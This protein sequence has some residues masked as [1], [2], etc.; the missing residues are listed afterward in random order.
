VEFRSNAK[1]S[2]KYYGPFKILKKIGSV[3]YLLDLP[4]D[5]KLHPVFHISVLKQHVGTAEPTEIELPVVPDSPIQ[6]QS[7]LEQRMRKG[8]MEIIV[9]WM[10]FSLADASWEN[11]DDF[12]S[13]FPNF[14]LEDKDTS[15]EGGMLQS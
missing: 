14:V 12:I 15:K 13:R 1:L 5:S 10:G 3:A 4:K 2:T 11:K 9:H 7:V 8:T 6:P